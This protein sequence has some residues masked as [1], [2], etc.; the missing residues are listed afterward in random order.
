MWG[1]SVNTALATT[2][3]VTHTSRVCQ[4][5]CVNFLYFLLAVENDRQIYFINVSA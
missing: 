2:A 1:L 3:S 5:K 4:V